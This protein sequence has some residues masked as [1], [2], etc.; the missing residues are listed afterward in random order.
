M[1]DIKS[2]KRQVTG[3]KSCGYPYQFIQI[4]SAAMRTMKT[5]PL[6]MSANP[7][8]AKATPTKSMKAT[9]LS[10]MKTT[11]MRAVTTMKA[12]K[13]TSVKSVGAMKAHAY[14]ANNDDHLYEVA[15]C[16]W[17]HIFQSAVILG[18]IT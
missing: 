10:S 8:A 18:N 12:M 17:Q 6:A 7:V 13:T 2:L 5:T 11:H 15:P 4:S 9:R 14:A 1:F 3:F 16:D